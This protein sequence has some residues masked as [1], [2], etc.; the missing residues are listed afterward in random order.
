M[1]ADNDI[2]SI[3][4][5]KF[6]GRS[7][8]HLTAGD[9]ADIRAEIVR[10][11]GEAESM[12]QMA[13]MQAARADAAEREVT[14]LRSIASAEAKGDAPQR[15][16]ECMH[17]T[18]ERRHDGSHICVHCKS[19]APQPAEAK[20]P[21][22]AMPNG[23]EGL[24]QLARNWCL[25]WG[26]WAHDA[27]PG[28]ANENAAEAALRAALTTALAK[29]PAEAFDPSIHPIPGEGQQP[30]MLNGVEEAEEVL[31]SALG[32]ARKINQDESGDEWLNLS[33][34]LLRLLQK[35]LSPRVGLTIFRAADNRDAAGVDSEEDAY[36]IERMGKMLAEIAV[37]V[38]GPEPDMTRW[39]YHDLPAKVAALA[40]QQAV[41]VP[42]GW[43][44]VPREPT[45]EMIEAGI[46]FGNSPNKAA[47]I[48]QN[49]LSAAP[50]PQ[51]GVS[52]G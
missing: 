31:R 12:E 11:R 47:I 46:L 18:F 42:E 13:R 3:V 17:T 20:T 49:M 43:V 21:A 44:V 32:I 22:P 7:F 45:R 10:L 39:S 50:T 23:V 29:P 2:V 41:A 24:M 16:K 9:W 51:K 38:N 30:A 37:I 14:H 15:C 52:D 4:D 34:D 28:G 26:E 8:I 33:A 35:A 6:S 25:A 1:T 40:A 19:I 36:V 27:D 48:Y 5:G